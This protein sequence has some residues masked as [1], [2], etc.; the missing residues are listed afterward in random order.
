ML[1]EWFS[2]ASSSMSESNT[3]VVSSSTSDTETYEDLT[4][5]LQ[6]PEQVQSWLQDTA[7]SDPAFLPQRRKRSRKKRLQLPRET[8]SLEDSPLGWSVPG[9]TKHK[10]IRGFVSFFFIETVFACV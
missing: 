4:V 8:I 6:K 7:S 9:P 5:D 2:T 3:V 10:G 1:R